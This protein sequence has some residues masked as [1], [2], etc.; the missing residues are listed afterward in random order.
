MARGPLI[1]RW[2][3]ARQ[4]WLE[5][6]ERAP[7]KRGRAVTGYQCMCLGWTDWVDAR[8]G[9]YTETLTDAGREKLAEWR[10]AQADSFAEKG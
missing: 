9:D 3:A 10:Q 6:L 8:S 2:T 1:A 4:A 7:A 5:T